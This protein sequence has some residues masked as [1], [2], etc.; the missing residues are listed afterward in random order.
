MTEINE[1]TVISIA[2]LRKLDV[3]KLLDDEQLAEVMASARL[4][5]Y[6]KRT[7]VVLKGREVDYLGFLLEGKLQVVDYLP[8]GKEFG[9]NLIERGQFYGELS[10]IDRR[11]RSA[12]VVAL[13]PVTVVQVPGEAARRMF[14]QYPAVAEAMMNYLALTVRRMSDLRALQAIPHAHQRVYALIGYVKHTVAGS[15]QVID[16]MPTHQE[17]A[18]MVNTSRE[19]VT[20]A[21][22]RLK[23]GGVIEKQARRLIIRRP[24]LLKRLIEETTNHQA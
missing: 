6:A 18:I 19:T 15:V 9:L 3:L 7:T 13:T 10:V 2:L 12:S 16:D 24:D 1:S 17:I 14:Y 20:R 8:D 5:R 4:V 22:A 23:S 11:P 21:L